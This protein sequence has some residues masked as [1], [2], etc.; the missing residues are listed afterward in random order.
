MKNKATF[1]LFFIVFILGGLSVH[2]IEDTLHPVITWFIFGVG[3]AMSIVA[4][5]ELRALGDT[6]IDEKHPAQGDD[7]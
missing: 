7:K 1:P 2:W 5:W 6:I 4:L 3:F